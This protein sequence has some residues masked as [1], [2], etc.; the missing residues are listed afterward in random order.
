MG[1]LFHRQEHGLPSQ[2][3]PPRTEMGAGQRLLWHKEHPA[4]GL[5]P[6]LGLVN[7]PCKGDRGPSSP[8]GQR[9][10]R[11]GVGRAR[12]HVLPSKTLWVLGPNVQPGVYSIRSH[13][14]SCDC[15]YR[16]ICLSLQVS[17]CVLACST[18]MSDHICGYRS[19]CLSEVL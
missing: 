8:K 7:R 11:W 17:V 5:K 9:T 13:I 6:V 1:P 10:R 12:N 18:L 14:H 4:R 3:H 15:V 16:Y 2:S 19:L